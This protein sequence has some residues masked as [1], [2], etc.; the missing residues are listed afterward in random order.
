MN[1]TTDQQ[2]GRRALILLGGILL[3]RLIYAWLYP[4][5]LSGDEAY[6][7]DWGRHPA[8][9]YYSKPPMIGWIMALLRLLHA[10]HGIGIRM[11]STLI[12][13]GTLSLIYA[14][15]ARLFSPRAGFW[16]LCVMIATLANAALNICM[17]TDAPL[18]LFW[19]GALYCFWRLI[20]TPTRR[21]SVW[22]IL[23][24]GLG[25]LSKQMMLVFFPIALIALSLM[26]EKR[27]L[28]R[29]PILWISGLVPLLFLIPPFLWNAQHDW[30]TFQHTAHHMESEPFSILKSL[31]QTGEFLATQLGLATPVIFVLL[32][33]IFVLLVKRWNTL[34][35]AERYLLLLSAPPLLLFLL[36]SFKQEINPNWPL[37]YYLPGTILMTGVCCERNGRLFSWLKRGVVVGAVLTVAFYSSLLILPA[38]GMDITRVGPFRQISGWAEYGEAVARVQRQLPDPENTMLIVTGHRTSTAAL[39]FYHPDRPTVYRWDSN[40][41][42]INNQYDIWPGPSGKKSSALLIAYRDDQ[43][44]ADL[45]ARFEHITALETLEIPPNTHKPK[46]YSL[47]YATGWKN[48]E[49]K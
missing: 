12:G 46:R 36:L 15:T 18:S 45:A 47:Y 43:V 4:F 8:W 17:T 31:A 44:P 28:L 20:E 10:D 9:G 11:A 29:R 32:I 16:A 7:W 6:Y 27:Q 42:L 25:A 1:D 22:L 3:F 37:V 19:C 38:T 13:T 35:S 30:I 23:C 34:R 2:W 14:L 33:V 39:A 24:I 40:P 21:W 49:T 26:P 48:D 41:N 5:S